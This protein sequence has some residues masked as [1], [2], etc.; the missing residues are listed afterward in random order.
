M[1]SFGLSKE[2]MNKFLNQTPVEVQGTSVWPFGPSFSTAPV[3]ALRKVSNGA[4]GGL[5][6]WTTFQELES[7]QQLVDS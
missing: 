4:L 3:V 1:A 6:K 7:R 5:W 2:P